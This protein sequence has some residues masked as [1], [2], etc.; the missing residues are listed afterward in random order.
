MAVYRGQAMNAVASQH[1]AAAAVCG[2]AVPAWLG[3][4]A[5]SHETRAVLTETTRPGSQTSYLSQQLYC[6]AVWRAP[7]QAASAAA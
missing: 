4:N 2:R 7:E 3:P 6:S 1:R 5:I